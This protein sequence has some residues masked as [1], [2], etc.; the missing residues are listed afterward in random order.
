MLQLVRYVDRTSKTK[1]WSVWLS[2]GLANLKECIN[3]WWGTA[4][5]KFKKKNRS[6][7]AFHNFRFCQI[8]IAASRLSVKIGITLYSKVSKRA[9]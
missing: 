7:V 8:F 1:V 3:E 4:A 2:G 5:S 9:I 6:A